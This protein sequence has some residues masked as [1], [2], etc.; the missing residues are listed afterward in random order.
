MIQLCIFFISTPRILWWLTSS[1]LQLQKIF[2]ALFASKVSWK[3]K[4]FILMFLTYISYYSPNIRSS[5]ITLGCFSNG[6]MISWCIILIKKSFSL[7]LLEGS[8]QKLHWQIYVPLCIH[9]NARC[10]LYSFPCVCET[11]L[12]SQANL[13]KSTHIW[14]GFALSMM[15]MRIFIISDWITWQKMGKVFSEQN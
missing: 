15:W 1:F 3:I 5:A 12:S 11:F 13:S 6:K 7:L 14:Q 10:V 8:L 9:K 4:L 2:F